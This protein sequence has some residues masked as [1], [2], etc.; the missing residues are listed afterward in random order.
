M[1]KLNLSTTTQNNSNLESFFQQ[2][3]DQF[4]KTYIKSN[5]IIDESIVYA[6]EAPGKRVIRVLK[7]RPQQMLI[8]KT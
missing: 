2:R 7:P 4:L 8:P 5:N 6:L 1:G 3:V